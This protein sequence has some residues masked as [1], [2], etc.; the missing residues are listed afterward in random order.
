MSFLWGASPA[1]V[2]FDALLDKTT[3]D[4]LPSTAP[5]DLAAS[6]QLADL[7]R[8][9]AVPP[10]S[11]S[12]SLLKRLLHDNPNVQLLALDV[13]DVCIKNGGTP[14][15]VAVA[16][17]EPASDL[18]ALARGARPDSNRDVR[19]KVRVKVQDWAT[20]FRGKDQLRDSE[21]V[22][23][24]DRMRNEGLPFPARDPTAT[25]AMVDSLSAPDWDDAPY[26]TRCRT[27]FTTFNRKHHCRNCGHVFD[28]ACSSQTAPLPHYGITEEVRVCD[29]CAK[30]IKEGKGA[31][32]ARSQSVAKAAT[33]GDSKTAPTASGGHGKSASRKEQEDEDLRRAIEASLKDAEPVPGPLRTAAP[34]AVSGYNPGYASSLAVDSKAS[35]VDDADDPDLA[36]AIAASLR[37]IAPPP[38]APTFARQD[39]STAPP[40]TYSSL[41][42]SD[43][44]YAP[45]PSL[46]SNRPRLTL[47]SYDLTPSETSVLSTFSSTFSPAQ[48]PPYIGPKERQLYAQAAEAH[49]RLERGLEDARRRGHILREMEWKLSEAARLYGA[50]LTE[51]SSTSSASP[52]LY[53]PFRWLVLALMSSRNSGYA[54]PLHYPP[55][56]TYASPPPLASPTSL[57]FA[58]DPRYQYAPPP[59]LAGQPLPFALAPPQPPIS[60][61]QPAPPNPIHSPP[62][63]LAEPPRHQHVAAPP[64][65]QQ[66]HVPAPAG[67]YKP[68]QF[69]SVP[70]GAQAQLFP[71]V[72]NA[73]PW[74]RDREEEEEEETEERVGELIEL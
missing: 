34:P 33:K 48:P 59:S 31:E 10:Q 42:P 35:A 60:N 4:L 8:S 32:V 22:R 71:S 29:G 52:L 17:K 6:L 37:D 68:S 46:S 54:Q 16:N 30:K 50:G 9:A 51:R 70:T 62:V 72:P 38:T 20:A 36:A 44:A 66:Q 53:T 1:Q 43:P 27:E 23:A 74:R 19:D 49:P 45:A 65:A 25:A 13:L 2:E 15:L 3:S 14:F 40:L 61:S 18:E 5:V 24:Y 21:L 58:P 57:A 11:A 64:A 55:Q 56:Q 28:A 47:P 39:S 67:Y 41:F 69:P 7:I 63:S 26:C 12:T 73:E